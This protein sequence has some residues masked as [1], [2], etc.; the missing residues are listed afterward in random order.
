ML[1]WISWAIFNSLSILSL[2]AVVSVSCL[3]YSLQGRLHVAE[4]LGQSFPTSSPD[5][6]MGRSTPGSPLAIVSCCPGHCPQRVG[7]RTGDDRRSQSKRSRSP[8]RLA[9]MRTI[10]LSRVDIRHQLVLWEKDR[11][12]PAVGGNGRIIASSI[13]CR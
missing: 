9:R 6:T 2:A 13:A 1:I 4:G 7:D 12:G 11:E 5:F 3:M 8:A 10:R